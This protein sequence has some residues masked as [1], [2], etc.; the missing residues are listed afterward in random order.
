MIKE[1]FLYI[2]PMVISI[3]PVN[4]SE[5]RISTSIRPTLN[6]LPERNLAKPASSVP[7]LK[8]ETATLAPKAMYMP[9]SMP[10]IK[11]SNIVSLAFF[12][13]ILLMVFDIS[14][15]E[16]IIHVTLS[17]LRF[18]IKGLIGLFNA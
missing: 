5:P 8:T 12:S 6:T 2:R 3:L 7:P 10:N 18:Y 17:F 14:K 11:S 13:P 9:A 15:G 16:K 1:Y 4:N